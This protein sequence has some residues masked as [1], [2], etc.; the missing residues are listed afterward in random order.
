MCYAFARYPASVQPRCGGGDIMVSDIQ[1]HGGCS[2]TYRNT[3]SEWLSLSPSASSA[4]ATSDMMAWWN[5]W[6]AQ[7]D[8]IT[9]IESDLNQ[10]RESDKEIMSRRLS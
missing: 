2:H 3:F 4:A 1:T 9:L 7:E 6:R 5:L 8:N 10:R